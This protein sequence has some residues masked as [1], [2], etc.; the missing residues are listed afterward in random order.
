M[1]QKNQGFVLVTSVLI[2]TTLL[3]VGSYLIS[4]ANSENKIAQ[5]EFLATKN[6]YLSEAG[7]SEMLWRIKND[8]A[9]RNAFLAGTLDE[10]FNISR[11]NV[12][13]DSKASYQ[14][15]AQNTVT[16]EAW[17]TATSTYQIGNNTSQRVVKSYISKATG[18]PSGWNYSVYAGGRGGQQNGNFIFTGSGVALIA[19]GGRLHANQVFKVQ[20]AEVVVNDGAVTSANV[21]EVVA[22]GALTL[23]TSYQDAPTSTVEIIPITINRDPENPEE[24]SWE[25]RATATYTT[26]AFN[27]LPDNTVLTGI[28]YVSGSNARIINKNL[29]INGVLAAGGSLEADLDGQ[30]FIVNHDETY[31]SGV[32]VNNNLTIT[33]EG[34]LVLI[35]GLIYSGNTLEINSQNTDFTINGALAGFDATVTASG[36]PITLNFTAANVDPVINPEYNPDSPLIQIDHWEEQY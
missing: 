32:L 6:Y 19:N 9:A 21:I 2:L 33:T 28:I 18:D 29:T 15:S 23:N 26:A 10:S 36:R 17:I 31:D 34:G 11:S 7:I 3:A 35:D 20:K 25:K 14:V 12:F 13:G 24:N 27:S 30:S 8:A 1:S 16:A 5:A 22:G 4:S